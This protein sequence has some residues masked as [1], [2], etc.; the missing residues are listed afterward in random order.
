MSLPPKANPSG[1]V[2][3]RTPLG[4]IDCN[5]CSGSAL[6]S[7]F[8]LASAPERDDVSRHLLPVGECP[9]CRVTD[10]KPGEARC[11]AT[12][13]AYGVTH[14]C[15][16]EATLL[17]PGLGT[18]CERHATMKAM[19]IRAVVEMVSGAT[20]EPKLRPLLIPD[21]VT[22]SKALRNANAST[23]IPAAA[24]DPEEG[25]V[26]FTLTARGEAVL[27]YSRREGHRSSGLVRR[28]PLK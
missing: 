7:R 2:P 5:L 9:S 23:G 17:E 10:R 19:P 15:G 14:W 18:V 22:P 24:P 21:G 26:G 8:V 11:I 20:P 13:Q 6:I 4:K 16:H 25:L 12:F 28:V 1:V 3:I 27:S